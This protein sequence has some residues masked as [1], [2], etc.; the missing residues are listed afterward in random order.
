MAETV[1]GIDGWWAA[2]RSGLEPDPV[3]TVSQWADAHRILSGASASEPGPWR[4]DRAPY[5]REIMDRL[6]ATSRTELVVWQAAS[7]TGKT[8]A[9]LNWIG[10]VI[11]HAPG[12]FLLLEPTGDMAK[13]LS[14]GRLAPMIETTPA[15]AERVADPRSR[16]AANTVRAKQFPG[17]ELFIRGANSPAQLS[18]TPIRY[19]FLDEVD[20]YPPEAGEEGD[21][22]DLAI[23]RSATFARRKILMTST[24]TVAGVSRIARAMATV[25]CRRYHLPCPECGEYQVLEWS[26]VVW[27]D[28][29]RP[30]EE[31]AY[32]CSAC[33]AVIE[34]RFKAAMLARG[35]WR[36]VDPAGAPTGEPKRVGYYLSA[37]YSPWKSWGEIAAQFVEVK[38]DPPRLKAWT[39]LQLGE[40][41][42]DSAAGEGFGDDALG[43]LLQRV[44]AEGWDGS[45]VPPGV[46]FLTAGVDVQ[47]D[48]FELEVVGWGRG[49]ES[50][51]LD[52]QILHCDTADP[53]A[54]AA[55]DDSLVQLYR[56]DET[57]HYHIV[58]VAIDSGGHR[59]Q[60]AYEFAR[61]RG[62]RKLS[63]SRRQFVWAIKG[64]A[65]DRRIWSALPARSDRHQRAP[66]YMVGV[67]SAKA[68]VYDRLRVAEP[69]PGCCHF[70]VDRDREFYLQLTSEYRHRY[71]VRGRWLTQWRQRTGQR[72]EALDC[73][74]YA[75]AAACGLALKGLT[76]E[77]VL[78]KPTAEAPSTTTGSPTPAPAA[79]QPDAPPPVRKK[80]G[81]SAAEWW[82]RVKHDNGLAGWN[83]HDW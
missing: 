5:L 17:G 79:G 41:W 56:R 75:Y 22:L 35:E 63:E 28:L 49:M 8:E 7:Q 12:P 73:R 55:L 76:P 69:G 52:Y 36:W 58:G 14:Q 38:N 81:M 19:L 18:S 10:Y 59:T 21:P 25:P 4:T 50:W 16:D 80:R 83:S 51:S 42:D 70:P 3:L 34:H 44:T 1:R 47:D 61:R 24:P 23:Q 54:W 32:R 68:D 40:C 39:N 48:R 60:Q 72:N 13:D 65:G 30:P 66:V 2:G 53:G 64:L 31:A 82:E 78:P 29:K 26:G 9:G 46:A 45:T 57:H 27:S 37:L 74:V 11:H 71:V 15:L 67:D 62:V 33:A 77:R 6:S 20:R 43:K